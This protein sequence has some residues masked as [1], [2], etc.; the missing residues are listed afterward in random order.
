MLFIQLYIINSVIFV[1]DSDVMYCIIYY[2]ILLIGCNYYYF[3]GLRFV[4]VKDSLYLDIDLRLV[5]QF[6]LKYLEYCF[7]GLEGRKKIGVNSLCCIWGGGYLG[8]NKSGNLFNGI[9]QNCIFYY[10]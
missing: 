2:R 3:F 5:F 8:I 6:W 7:C 10:M 1:K 4:F 9:F